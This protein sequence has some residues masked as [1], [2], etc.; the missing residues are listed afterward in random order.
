MN[1]HDLLIRLGFASGQRVAILHA[2]DVG[3]CHGANAAFLDLAR[4]GHL[5]CGSVMMP[6]PWSPEIARVAA[7]DKSLDLG[8]HLTLTSEWAGYRWGP[9]TRAGKASGLVDD[10]GYFPRT[11]AALVQGVAAEAAEGEMRAQID[12]ALAFGIDVTHLDTHMGA[13]LSPP[14]I[15][16]YCR[17]GRD[18]RLPVL[19]PRRVDYYARVLKL[20]CLGA[21][22][23]LS[24]A[25][26][27]V[28]GEGVPLVDDFRMTPGAAS[29]ESAAAYR[30]LVETLPDG[31]T[32]VA[33]HPNKSGDIE[34]IVPPRAHHRTDEVR[35][36]GSGAIADWLEEN[37]IGTI[38]LRPLRDLY[39]EAV[40][41]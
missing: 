12:R 19:L 39:R 41:R 36:L 15:E 22:Q 26:K 13:A 38:G 29:E 34:T 9:L 7:E 14:L 2:D 17:V 3:M 30:E 1:S 6:C 10:E 21:N 35:L 28:E 33:L 8:V 25:A 4:A 40:S 20:D 11:V 31:L 32:F 23:A 5:T 16:A 27:Q 18:Y 24:D 37:G